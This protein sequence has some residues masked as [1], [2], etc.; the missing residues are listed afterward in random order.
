M[1][2]AFH[3]ITIDGND[4]GPVVTF[5]QGEG[6]NAE[7]SGFTITRGLYNA[8][9]AIL[10]VGSHPMISHCV[11]AGNRTTDPDFGAAVYCM[12]SATTLQNCTVADNLGGEHGAGI[13]LVDSSIT[14]WNSI[15]WGNTSSQ[16][17][18]ESGNDPAV[19]YSSISGTWPG[20]GNIDKGP[21]FANSGYWS[22]PADPNLLLDPQEPDAVWFAGDY[23][24]KSLVGRWSPNGG[25]W[26]L[27][28]VASPCIDAGDPNADWAIE[29]EP[30]GG[31]VNMGAY[32]GTIQASQSG[33]CQKV[34]LAIADAQQA[35]DAGLMVFTVRPSDAIPGGFTVD[36]QVNDG[37]A[38]ASDGDF[39]ARNSTLVFT[40]VAG[41]AKTFAV[42]INADTKLESDET[43][44]VS[45]GKLARLG[46]DIDSDCIDTSDTATG[47]IINDDVASLSGSWSVK[48]MGLAGGWPIR[49]DGT[50]V[51]VIFVFGVDAFTVTI[52]ESSALLCET[53]G[54]YTTTEDRLY[55]NPT[56]IT[57]SD[58]TSDFA[59]PAISEYAIAGDALTLT[60]VAD[61]PVWYELQRIN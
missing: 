28:D 6:P 31:R 9:S 21:V 58:C 4:Q 17:V 25:R 12:D 59:I 24:L 53:T 19:A 35:E 46:V 49:L 32:G 10:C 34:A 37:T 33:Q 23:H 55:L 22:D 3:E 50:N 2:T 48:S 8:G 47:T 43:F 41:E 54:T 26:I 14:I 18:V 40:G 29:P 7:L 38:S 52:R 20:D 56:G 61:D 30:N 5:T 13:Y 36:I 45:L 44:G 11:I 51:S 16:I 60:E 57:G 15:I 27:D 1:E 39:V 42:L